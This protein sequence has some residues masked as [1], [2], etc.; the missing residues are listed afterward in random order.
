MK[1]WQFF[2]I[3][4]LFFSSV[5]ADERPTVILIL[6]AKLKPYFQ[7]RDGF[8]RVYPQTQEFILPEEASLIRHN[9][10]RKNLLVV[11]VGSKAL[12]FIDQLPENF[13]LFYTLIVSPESALSLAPK[14]RPTCGIYLQLPPQITFPL[15]K[16]HLSY[17]FAGKEKLTIAIPFSTPEGKRFID[18]ARPIAQ[19]LGLQIMELPITPGKP[20]ENI[21]KKSW[22]KFDIFYFIPDPILFSETIIKFF[23]KQA[24]LHHKAVCGY[25]RFFY[26][27]GAALAFVIDYF[28]T[29]EKTAWLVIK[30][31]KGESCRPENAAFNVLINKKVL[32]FL[33]ES[34]LGDKLSK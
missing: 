14:H 6:S 3:F 15:V 31:L 17:L 9:L 1:T 19:K 23:I 10:K 27:Q 13:K 30:N 7:V 16:K 29:G 22:E 34:N 11:A 26:E 33:Q 2:L 32:N 4:C 25:N 21:L 8:R 12:S 28:Q 20:F 5:W 24:L 18:K